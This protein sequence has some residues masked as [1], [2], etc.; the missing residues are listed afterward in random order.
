MKKRGV[1]LSSQSICHQNTFYVVRTITSN[2]SRN[3]IDNQ[4]LPVS[5]NVVLENVSLEFDLVLIRN[6]S[7]ACACHLSIEIGECEETSCNLYIVHS[8]WCSFS[9]SF[10]SFSSQLCLFICYFSYKSKI[11]SNKILQTGDKNQNYWTKN[12]WN[13]NRKE[14]NNWISDSM[15][16][17]NLRRIQRI[18]S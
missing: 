15:Q 16:S 11:N 7:K 17:I 2:I 6:I 5:F 3:D 18:I 10:F 1:H 13:G 14:N 4:K 12:E 8:R 9:S